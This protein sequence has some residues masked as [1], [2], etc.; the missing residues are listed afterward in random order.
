M[1]RDRLNYNTWATEQDLRVYTALKFPFQPVLTDKDSVHIIQATVSPEI[2]VLDEIG[3]K[4]STYVVDDFSIPTVS[5]L[6]YDFKHRYFRKLRSPFSDPSK[7]SG[8]SA[9]TSWSS[10]SIELVTQNDAK[11]SSFSITDALFF[12]LSPSTLIQ[13]ARGLAIPHQLYDYQ[14]QGVEFLL[15]HNSALLGDDMG[16]GKTVMSIVA[17][18]RLFQL[19]QIRRALI[20]CPVAVI[21]QWQEHLES[22]ASEISEY[23]VVVRGKGRDQLWYSRNAVFITNYETLARDMAKTDS[24][25]LPKYD[26]IILDEA[27]R[28]KSQKTKNFRA[29][30]RLS[31][32]ARYRWALTGTPLQN[33]ISELQTLC[34][35]LRPDQHKVIQKIESAEQLRDYI[36]PFFLR[37]TKAEVLK[38]LPEKT[39]QDLWL[40]LSKRQHEAYIAVRDGFID[41]LRQVTPNTSK[42]E[43]TRVVIAKIQKLKQICNF[44]PETLNSPKIDDLLERLREIRDTGS[45]ALVFSQFVEEGVDKIVQ[46]L[47]EAL[48]EQSCAVIK[49]GQSDNER[50]GQIARFKRNPDTYIL[51]ASVKA[52][53]EGLNL[54]EANYVFH[55][56]HWWN[57]STMRQAEDRAHRRGQVR[58]VTVMSYWM[59]QTIDENIYDLLKEK[60]ELFNLV[61]DR[62]SD[63]SIANQFK[64]EE[65]IEI[66]SS[67]DK[68]ISPKRHTSRRGQPAGQLSIHDIR[69]AL[70]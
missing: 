3:L 67:T 50:Q 44:E 69:M 53:G 35:I 21:T 19:G 66:L 23:A 5:Y 30:E 31:R 24:S 15:N 26:L 68:N 14:K 18:R 2:T 25:E 9:E 57:P 34:L 64:P 43:Y 56:D 8:S 55:F 63:M 47:G 11:D 60:Q 51:V 59:S 52:A 36:A 1:K 41:Y 58:A 7:K 38:D 42:L 62:L 40:K 6:E 28:V 13:N 4:S 54:T 22:W 17:L 33:R 45:K 27:H 46:A 39:H 12:I 10:R 20:V 32:S 37:R 49:G 70:Y 16:T 65:W 29:V 48:G 61:I